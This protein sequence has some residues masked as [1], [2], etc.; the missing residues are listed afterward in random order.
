MSDRPWQ[1]LTYDHDEQ[2]ELGFNDTEAGHLAYVAFK[3]AHPTK[4]R[5]S[6][7]DLELMMSRAASA[8]VE[9]AKRVREIDAARA[10]E[11]VD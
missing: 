9:V 3:A 8:S 1:W 10:A 2:I 7:K 6:K 11:N 5:G 4:P